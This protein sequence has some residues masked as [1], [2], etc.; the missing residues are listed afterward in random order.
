MKINMA[1]ILIRCITIMEKTGNLAEAISSKA[2]KC[3]S[4]GNHEN[5]HKLY[6]K[7]T[8]GVMRNVR[9]DETNNNWT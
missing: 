6:D 2:D 3:F 5:I 4:V 7:T 9:N 8:K 1:A